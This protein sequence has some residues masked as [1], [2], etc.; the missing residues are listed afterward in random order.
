MS[1]GSVTFF[2]P[3]YCQENSYAYY[4]SKKGRGKQGESVHIILSF[5]SV[6]F[7][8]YRVISTT[9]NF[10]PTNHLQIAWLP[11]TL[12]HPC[13]HICQPSEPPTTAS[14]QIA[15]LLTNPLKVKINVCNRVTPF[16]SPSPWLGPIWHQ[17]SRCPDGGHFS[18]PA[19]AVLCQSTKSQFSGENLLAG[20]QLSGHVTSFVVYTWGYSEVRAKA[21]EER[22]GR[23]RRWGLYENRKFLEKQTH[24]PV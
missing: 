20:R 22:G 9:D 13:L 21:R 12:F 10:W 23:Q 16:L 19:L 11:L 3:R 7:H 6:F 8:S 1:V 15:W 4:S 2:S 24:L 14:T 5:K 17:A 18:A